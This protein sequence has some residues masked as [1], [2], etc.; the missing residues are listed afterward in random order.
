MNGED[1]FWQVPH[2]HSGYHF[3]N[4][5][6]D[7]ETG[8]WFKTI[9]NYY[10][11]YDVDLGYLHSKYITLKNPNIQPKEITEEFKHIKFLEKINESDKT[12][13]CMNFYERPDLFPKFY[14]LVHGF[15]LD[16]FDNPENIPGMTGKFGIKIHY[17]IP[18]NMYLMHIDEGLYNLDVD[19]SRLV[20]IH[21]MLSDWVPGQFMMYGNHVYQDWKAGDAHIFKWQ[22][23]PHAT[24]NASN[25]PR[26]MLQLT[27]L[28]TD[29]TRMFLN[30]T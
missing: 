6:K 21:V 22:D 18:G 5:I 29:D 30:E 26:P 28:M 9:G 12:L 7:T 23:T 16:F 25:A 4:N 13:T 3:D 14:E 2:K 17:Q 20:R 27:G 10:N 11:G 19:H 15:G 24:A 1:N 8:P